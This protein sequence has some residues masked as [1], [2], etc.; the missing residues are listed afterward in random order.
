MADLIVKAAVKEALEDKNVASD[1]YDALDCS[2]TPPAAPRPTTGRRS[3]PATCKALYSVVLFS[4]PERRGRL[5][6]PCC[7]RRG[8]SG[9][10]RPGSV[11]S[12]PV[13]VPTWSSSASPT[14]SPC[15]T[16][17]GVSASVPASAAGSVI[18]PNSQSSTR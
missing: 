11:T 13:S 18:G 14:N 16:T 5:G 9:H 6:L 8:P 10:S 17:P 1:F 2:K 7:V 15:S 4:H 3:S 12:T